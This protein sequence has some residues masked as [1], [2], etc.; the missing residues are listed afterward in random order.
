M[1]AVPLRGCRIACTALSGVNESAAFM[2]TYLGASWAPGLDHSTTHL[3]VTDMHD[4]TVSIA[5]K[6]CPWVKILH[7]HWL[8][9]CYRRCCRAVEDHY[10]ITFYMSARRTGT[11]TTLG[12]KDTFF[13][14]VGLY[15][16]VENQMSNFVGSP[17]RHVLRGKVHYDPREDIIWSTACRLLKDTVFWGPMIRERNWHGRRH[18][19]MA[20]AKAGDQC[21]PPR[22]RPR[23]CRDGPAHIMLRV[24]YLPW[25]L[26]KLIVMFV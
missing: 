8:C 26:R 19:M 3:L 25:E 23:K 21:K 16:R 5:E 15:H 1:C 18:V 20:L 10:E 9:K 13:T 7:L 12:S 22:K 2:A 14:E 11:R 6:Y 4:A 24:A 17:L